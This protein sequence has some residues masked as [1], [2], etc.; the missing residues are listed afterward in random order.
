MYN[1]YLIPVSLGAP[2]LAEPSLFVQ[3]LHT[4]VFKEPVLVGH[5]IGWV[6]PSL[7]PPMLFSLVQIVALPVVIKAPTRDPK[8]LGA[9]QVGT[10]CGGKNRANKS[11]SGVA[12]E[13]E[14]LLHVGRWFVAQWNRDKSLGNT[15]YPPLGDLF[16]A[17]TDQFLG[18]RAAGV[19]TGL[20]YGAVK[21]ALR[22]RGMSIHMRVSAR[23]LMRPAHNLASHWML[24]FVSHRMHRLVS[25]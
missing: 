6:P 19:I 15:A 25:P 13:L 14:V 17:I 3:R 20:D 5:V 9:R 18:Q 21:L 8:L 16:L 2:P 23:E 11:C 22:L 4:L 10:F 7:S 1:V 12:S 24:E